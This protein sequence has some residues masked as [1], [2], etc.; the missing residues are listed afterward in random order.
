MGIRNILIEGGSGSGKTTVAIELERLGHHVVHGDRTLAYQGDPATGQRLDP[1][2]VEHHR[3]DP[4]F[5]S[6]HHIWDIEAVKALVTDPTHRQT[7]FCGGSR[8]WSRFI[9]LFDA[10]LVL[11]IDRE[12]LERRL[13]GRPNEWGSEPSE[14]A[15][16]LHQH[17]TRADL[18]AQAISI[19]ANRP[20]SAVVQ[21]ILARCE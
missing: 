11:D 13:D 5:I 3:H 12:T 8:N 14:R 4:S 19:D 16:I 20:V 1:L 10:V 21:E 17:T 6:R 2:V 9:D 15:L 18:P 7:F